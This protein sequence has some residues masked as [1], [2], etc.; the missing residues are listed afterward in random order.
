[1]HTVTEYV[2]VVCLLHNYK[3]LEDW[4]S[5]Y[6]PGFLSKYITHVVKTS[7]GQNHVMCIQSICIKE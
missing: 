6:H 7:L 5:L 4:C 2:L 1:M 3:L